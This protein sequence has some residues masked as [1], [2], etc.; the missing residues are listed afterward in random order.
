MQNS[1]IPPTVHIIYIYVFVFNR[2]KYFIQI[3]TGITV[4]KNPSVL[5]ITYM[6]RM[7]FKI[8]QWFFLV[9]SSIFSVNLLFYNLFHLHCSKK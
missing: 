3:C 7:T 6:K 8:L 9:D 4:C 5:V 2:F 1:F